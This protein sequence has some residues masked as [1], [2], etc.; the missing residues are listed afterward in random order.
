MY[1]AKQQ[2]GDEDRGV[3]QREYLGFSDDDEAMAAEILMDYLSEPL[4]G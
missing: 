3:A 2:Y 1:G 4:E